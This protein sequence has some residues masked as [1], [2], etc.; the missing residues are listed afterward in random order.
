MKR[1]VRPDSPLWL[2]P[3]VTAALL[4]AYAPALHG[5]M[6]WDDDGHL[7]RAALRS[8]SG[9]LRIWF[10]P[11]ATQQYYPL[12]HSAFWVQARL[13]GDA[14]LGYHVV[15]VVLHA[16]SACLL[17]A[18]LRRLEIP[19]AVLAGVVFALHPVQAESVAWMTELKNTLSGVFYF[20]AA[21]AYLRYHRQPG[22]RAYA[23]SLALF[24]CALASKTVTATLPIALMA[25]FWWRRGSIDWRRDVKPLV[26]FVVLGA[27][28]GLMTAWVERTQ[29]GARGADF[30]LSPIDRV[31]VAGRA[32]LFYA[33][34][35]LWPAHLTFVYPRW[36]V[37]ED[38]WWQYLFPLAVL[39]LLAACWTIRHR[40][41]APLAA[42]L[43]FIATLAPALGFL[44]VYPFRYSF[45]ADHFQY[46]ACA[47]IFVPLAAA[48]T[49]LA[50]RT[51][52]TAAVAE[53]VLCVLIGVSLGVATHAE[54]A[55]YADAGTLYTVTLRSNSS[56]WLC[57]ENLGVAALYETPPQRDKAIELFR[58][59]LRINPAD[60]QLHNSLGTT[61][62]ELGQLDE[63]VAEHREAIRHA[64]GYAEA[65][66]NLGAALHKLG[67]LK[68]A[69]EAYRTALDIKPGLTVA[70][71]NLTILLTEMG[72]GEEAKAQLRQAAGGGTPAASGPAWA[73]AVQLGD[74]SAAVGEYA[75]AIGHYRDALA[76]G[77]DAPSTR[78]KLA[79]ALASTG[80]LADSATELRLVVRASPNDA[81][82]HANL[83]TV[84]MSLGQLDEAIAEFQQ[85]LRLDPNLPTAH[86]DL[87]VAL[88]RV[89]RRD[90]A[91]LH[92]REA[93][94][95]KPD[96]GPARA[97]LAKA[98]AR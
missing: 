70:R 39:L 38:V 67:R 18:V 50:M 63:A 48:L 5:T 66:G 10:E 58:H 33:R 55:K 64:P 49:R 23:L 95:L 30:A 46:L 76:R 62:M 37:S 16:A 56:C 2:F 41:R 20:A 40:S 65:Y 98:T 96:Y 90:E 68:E 6:L 15:N 88:A 53:G 73:A 87:G 17:V 25:A 27:A 86:N 13:W 84:L 42:S 24:C 83:A 26:P 11:G 91:I 32:V 75:A 44:N 34:T 28:A 78:M 81:S 31:L 51:G 52:L 69:E 14:Y 74:A 1:P 54:A 85:S 94:R 47:A 29:I 89:G 92:F 59:A 19:G 79:I 43:T 22:V 57:L 7:T 21:L 93:L 36:S 35:D 61:L 3:V 71:T 80:A 4:A 45:V 12:V 9:L 8:W 60:A 72:Q 82:A 77:A 97:N